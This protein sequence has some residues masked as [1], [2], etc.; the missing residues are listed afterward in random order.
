MKLTKI[1]GKCKKKLDLSEFDIRNHS[2]DGHT[3]LC[4][5]CR[6]EHTKKGGVGYK[7]YRA[8]QT[9]YQLDYY[10]LLKDI[11]WYKERR[12]KYRQTFLKKHPGYY[13]EYNRLRVQ[14]D[15]TF[16][17]KMYRRQLE[18]HPNYNKIRYIKKQIKKLNEK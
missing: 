4:K 13:R 7:V 18:L 11:P 12:E 1:C 15:P 2:K 6:Y 17:K 3:S 9:P 5:K 14:K 8:Y 10:H 16:Y